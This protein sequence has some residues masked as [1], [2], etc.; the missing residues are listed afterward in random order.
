[1]SKSLQ[2]IIRNESGETRQILNRSVVNGESYN[3]P[4]NQWLKAYEDDNLKSL[5]SSGEYIVNDGFS[6]LSP[7]EGLILI[8]KFQPSD[9]QEFSRKYITQWTVHKVKS[10][11][12]S[13]S[14]ASWFDAHPSMYSTG[15]Y[16][17]YNANI[18]PFI[19]PYNCKVS[20]VTLTFRRARF[21]WRSSAGNLLFEF[22]FYRMTHNSHED[23]CRLGIELEGSFSGNDTNINTFSYEVF[24]F[25]E[26]VGD[27]L[28]FAKD[29]LGV[30]FR[31]DISNPG[32]IYSIYDPIVCFELKEV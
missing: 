19:V 28:F 27:N 3:I 2:K 11:N 4:A 18:M 13:M 29:I 12:R 23:I 14:N 1:M 32:Q 24:N 16:S 21:D 17:G 20:K 6:D 8:D 31:K 26:R 7:A 15:S 22:G 30:Q 10:G 5:V 25:T 9:N